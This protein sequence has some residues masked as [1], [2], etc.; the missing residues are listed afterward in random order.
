MR[1]LSY[2]QRTNLSGTVKWNNYNVSRTFKVYKGVKQG[3]VSSLILYCIF[4]NKLI[5]KLRVYCS[6]CQLGRVFIGIFVYADDIILLGGV[7]ISIF[8]YADDII[9]LGGVFMGIFVYADDIILLGG[10]FMGIFV[11]ADDIILLAPSRNGLQYMKNV[12]EQFAN[13]LSMK[14]LTCS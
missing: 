4:M 7:F 8:V 6:G 9:L 10:V 14:F 3:A 1:T 5:S 2:I 12:C 11:Y 13:L